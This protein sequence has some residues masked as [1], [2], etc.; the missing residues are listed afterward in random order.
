MAPALHFIDSHEVL[1]AV[2][3][4]NTRVLVGKLARA[5]DPKS[6]YRHERWTLAK[7]KWHG[8]THD[9]A[10]ATIDAEG[11]RPLRG[12]KPRDLKCTHV[13]TFV[14]VR[15]GDLTRACAAQRKLVGKSFGYES[16]VTVRVHTGG[17]TLASHGAASMTTELKAISESAATDGLGAVVV[18][19][20]AL[21][22]AVKDH[23]SD[24]DVTIERAKN[25]AP[26][27]VL[28]SSKTSALW[29][30]STP[31][32][33]VQ[34][35]KTEPVDYGLTAAIVRALAFASTD[36]AR[37]NIACIH[38]RGRE[39]DVVD[40]C[41]TDG[42]RLYRER[43]A[44]SALGTRSYTIARSVLTSLRA[45]KRA[46]PY[47]FDFRDDGSCVVACDG[48]EVECA[49]YGWTFPPYDQIVPNLAD[50]LSYP[51]AELPHDVVT[52][53]AKWLDA[54]EVSYDTKGNIS[55]L[56]IEAVQ[57]TEGVTALQFISSTGHNFT[58]A[59]DVPDFMMAR[60][61]CMPGTPACDRV[62]VNPLYLRQ[63]L[64]TFDRLPAMRMH[65][66]GAKEPI[67]FFDDNRV[68]VIMSM[69]L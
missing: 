38:L 27:L 63:A 32:L 58:A 10:N 68:N 8:E 44:C 42:H 14:K 54:Q 26:V 50:A 66:S 29:T 12:G 59:C 31:T 6:L 7:S 20:E 11:W 18:F 13:P 64:A 4:T 57:I 62:G 16:L 56:R 1:L 53:L 17:V 65:A 23:G 25:G 41:A 35:A 15:I 47:C 24:P 21:K 60:L 30:V 19:G 45:A 52:G 67:Y 69:Q 49:R 2:D 3:F 46:G 61:L 40:V 28:R 5:R 43:V 39:G 51:H 36:E 48:R 9:D 37:G 22:A 34:V 55:P 33:A